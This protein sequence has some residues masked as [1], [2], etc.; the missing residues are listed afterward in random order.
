MSAKGQPKLI[1]GMHT[2]RFY[3]VWK[4]MKSRCRR[5]EKN[6]NWY[7]HLTLDPSWQ[8]FLNFKRDMYQTYLEHVEAHGEKKTSIDRIDG[9]K[10]YSKKNCR[11]A[12]PRQ[13]TRN[14]W[15]VK[16]YTYRGKS[17][18]L[19]D[20]ARFIGKHRSFL[21]ARL[22]RGWPFAKA[23]TLKPMPKNSIQK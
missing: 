14:R 3:S 6:E 22:D 8:D 11:W 16:L 5:P 13:Q 1:H 2:T 15:N 23:L 17:L 20:W 19:A 9:T 21:Q 7:R 10:G 12:T 18:N 4:N